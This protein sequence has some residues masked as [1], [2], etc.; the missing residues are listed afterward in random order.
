MSETSMSIEETN[1]I[2][3]SLGLKTLRQKENNVQTTYSQPLTKNTL[4]EYE[5][6]NVNLQAANEVLERLEKSKK[7]RLMNEKL[8]G[9]TIADD[10]YLVGLQQT[11]D[12]GY[13]MVGSVHS[14]NIQVSFNRIINKFF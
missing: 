5:K 8:L 11:P 6:Q 12:G 3:L 2:R 1:K 14:T 9:P 10:D 4:V 7:K 13:L